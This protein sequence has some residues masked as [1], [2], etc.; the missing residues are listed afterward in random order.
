MRF[1]AKIKLFLLLHGGMAKPDS[2]ADLCLFDE[3]GRNGAEIETKL[4]LGGSQ[5]RPRQVWS[6]DDDSVDDSVDVATVGNGS[7]TGSPTRRRSRLRYWLG[8]V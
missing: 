8:V 7:I 2:E 3:A 5:K 4:L 6:A 1:Y